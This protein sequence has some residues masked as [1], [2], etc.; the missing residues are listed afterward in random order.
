MSSG[1]AV[2]AGR[3]GLDD[4]PRQYGTPR[5]RAA[6]ALVLLAEQPQHVRQCLC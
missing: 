5:N 1:G 6:R 4:L 3:Y 2:R